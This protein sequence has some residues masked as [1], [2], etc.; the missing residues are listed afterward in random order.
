MPHSTTGEA[1]CDITDPVST[2]PWF[3]FGLT[4]LAFP[5]MAKLDTSRLQ[6]AVS[7]HYIEQTETSKL[8]P[9]TLTSDQHGSHLG[10]SV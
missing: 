1:D 6:T 8:L 2:H 5:L 7:A 9:L 4:T 3:T 10:K